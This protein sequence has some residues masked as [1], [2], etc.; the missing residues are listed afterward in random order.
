MGMI[1]Q[2]I[3]N[4]TVGC[5]HAFFIFLSRLTSTVNFMK[6]EQILVVVVV[7]VAVVVVVVVL[8]LVKKTD[9][10][11]LHTHPQGGRSLFIETFKLL[12]P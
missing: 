7:V 9:P 12:L 3:Y 6:A 2:T 10:I 11:L 5:V 1:L 8:V 4:Q